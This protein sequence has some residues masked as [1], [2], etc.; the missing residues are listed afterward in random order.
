MVR[1]YVKIA[2]RNLTRYEVFSAINIVGLATGM[3]VTMLIGLWVHDELSFD[4][5]YPY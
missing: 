3:A 4:R 5:Q 1:N 2:W